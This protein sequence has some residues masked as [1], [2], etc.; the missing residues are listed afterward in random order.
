MKTIYSIIDIVNN[1]I[2]MDD[3]DP[4]MIFPRQSDDI[5]THPIKWLAVRGLFAQTE[6]RD[7]LMFS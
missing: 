3:C 7:L 6:S 2:T 4:Q 5:R 1:I